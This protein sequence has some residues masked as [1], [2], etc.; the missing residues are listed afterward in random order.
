MPDEKPITA[1]SHTLLDSALGREKVKPKAAAYPPEQGQQVYRFKASLKYRRDLWRRIEI[2]GSQT[3]QDLDDILRSEFNHDSFD[4]M[5]GFWH[6]VR[7][8]D[9]KRSRELELATL[10]PFG[11]PSEGENTRI[12][13]IG[14]AV[15]DEMKYVYDFG[16]WVEHSLKL[17]AVGASEAGARYPRVVARNKPQYQDCE[18]CARLGRQT[19]A[20]WI[21]VHCS[22]EQGREVLVCKDCLF[23]E[24]EDHY[25]NELVY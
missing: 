15:G 25:A 22:N 13:G 4:H 20:T 9:T 3:L 10:A 12:A 8:G 14:L 5:S 21:C 1:E 18:R 11:G 16:D 24:H 23:A 2:Q 17:E 7:R 19:R 6:K